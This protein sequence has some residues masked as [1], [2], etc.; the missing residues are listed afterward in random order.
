VQTA[1]LVRRD[2]L[3][4]REL[5]QNDRIGPME[6]EGGRHAGAGDGRDVQ[7]KPIAVPVEFKGYAGVAHL[8][9]LGAPPAIAV[10]RQPDAPVGTSVR[11]RLMGDK[12]LDV[13]TQPPLIGCP[14]S[15]TLH[16]PRHGADAVGFG[17]THELGK[18]STFEG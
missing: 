15:T 10:L 16:R 14:D 18:D 2:D 1:Q 11:D 3:L 6:I 7:A 13:H 12:G 8:H 5:L 4:G 9:N 17:P